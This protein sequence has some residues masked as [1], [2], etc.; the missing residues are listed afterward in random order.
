MSK[1]PHLDKAL[2]CFSWSPWG[3]VVI[4]T[5]SI[6]VLNCCGWNP[7]YYPKITWLPS[8]GLPRGYQFALQMQSIH[9]NGGQPGVISTWRGIWQGLKPFWV[10]ITGGKAAIVISWLE[11]RICQTSWVQRDW[12]NGSSSFT[13]HLHTKQ[14]HVKEY[15]HGTKV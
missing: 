5:G 12:Y 1:L 11:D 4:F 10:V 14:I 6:H 3:F 2:E 7:L 9:S 13:E 8:H 15:N